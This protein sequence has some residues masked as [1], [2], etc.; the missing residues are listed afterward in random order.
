MTNV[1]VLNHGTTSQHTPWDKNL[2]SEIGRVYGVSFNDALHLYGFSSAA[3]AVLVYPGFGTSQFNAK[4]N[5]NQTIRKSWRLKIANI[6]LSSDKVR[7]VTQDA[8]KLEQTVEAK[9]WIDDAASWLWDDLDIITN[10]NRKNVDHIL[11]IGWSRGAILTWYQI[12][13]F[14]YTH[15][16]TANYQVLAIDPSYGP[17]VY[18]AAANRA[19]EKANR[20][21]EILM[22]YQLGGPLSK[23]RA[24]DPFMTP[25]PSTNPH[26]RDFL[27]GIHGSAVEEDGYGN[28]KLLGAGIVGE[29]IAES[30]CGFTHFFPRPT[31][32]ERRQVYATCKN[33]L[34]SMNY[35]SC[36]RIYVQAKYEAYKNNQ[37]WAKTGYFFNEDDYK[38]MNFKYPTIVKALRHLPYDIRLLRNEYATIKQSEPELAK[39]LYRWADHTH[40]H[41]DH[42]F[43]FR[44]HGVR[45]TA[46]KE[47]I[48]EAGWR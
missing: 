15:K 4:L 39:S 18:K 31:P 38:A 43:A 24:Y 40:V 1:L 10:G 20:I 6:E 47:F 8:I 30:Q 19:Q 32:R 48:K 17:A 45:V 26:R 14:F 23:N 37:P 21:W 7:E 3:H 2:L 5:F 22:M 9:D 41:A 28:I 46:A 13:D 25:Y 11:F 27:P 33:N 29:F 36:R 44:V 34:T 16:C 12:Y 35:S 42:G